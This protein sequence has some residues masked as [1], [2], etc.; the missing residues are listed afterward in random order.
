MSCHLSSPDVHPLTVARWCL[1]TIS[2]VVSWWRVCTFSW[3][4]PFDHFIILKR[5]IYNE[6]LQFESHPDSALL[7]LYAVH[8]IWIYEN[9][10]VVFVKS[11]PSPTKDFGTWNQFLQTCCLLFR[12]KNKCVCVCVCDGAKTTIR[13]EVPSHWCIHVGG[14][15][16]PTVWVTYLFN[17]NLFYEGHLFLIVIIHCET[18]FKQGFTYMVTKTSA[19][20]DF[21][22][23]LQWVLV[24]FREHD[25]HCFHSSNTNTISCVVILFEPPISKSLDWR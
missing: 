4:L 18:M 2:V 14:C 16:N 23:N 19:A 20:G 22:A 15:Q 25:F 12:W 9:S 6:S 11:L 7:R 17:H 13:Q 24:K 21:E 1:Y 5:I 3:Y 8:L 10:D